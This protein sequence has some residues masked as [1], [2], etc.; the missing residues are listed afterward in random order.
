MAFGS[1]LQ[2]PVFVLYHVL[3]DVIR[4]KRLFGNTCDDVYRVIHRM[5]TIPHNPHR[6]THVEFPDKSILIFLRNSTSGVLQQNI[7]NVNNFV[8]F[9]IK[10]LY[11]PN[12][13][14]YTM[15]YFI[16]HK[17]LRRIYKSNYVIFRNKRG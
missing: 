1:V 6:V 5:Y 14:T 11:Q 16:R 17:Q 2:P 7:E 10:N 15:Y 8:V 3:F 12:I 4:A 9:F 13:K